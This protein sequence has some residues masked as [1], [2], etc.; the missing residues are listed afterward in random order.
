MELGVCLHDFE[1]HDSLGIEHVRV[2]ALGHDA[3]L[4]R[5]AGPLQR[6]TRNVSC[7]ADNMQRGRHAADN[8]ADDAAD[9]ARATRHTGPLRS[10]AVRRL[11]VAWCLLQSAAESPGMFQR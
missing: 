1:R 5:H 9:D 2:D 10:P 4:V 7:T 8:A 3:Y 6:A 11:Y